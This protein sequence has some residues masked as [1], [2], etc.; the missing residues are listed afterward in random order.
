MT[1][2]SQQRSDVYAQPVWETIGGDVLRPGGLALTERALGL[3][4]IAPGARLLDAGCGPGASAA[5]AARLGYASVGLDQSAFLLRQARDRHGTLALLRAAAERLPLASATIDAVLAECSLSVVSERGE[6]LGEF[7][8][9][10]KPGGVLAV[11]DVYARNPDGL[12]A[13]RRLP[14]DACLSGALSEQQI[15]DMLRAHGFRLITWEDHS[16]T[17]KAMA[18]RMAATCGGVAGLCEQTAQVDPFDLQLAL[19]RARLGYF[20]LVAT[21]LA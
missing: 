9:V 21:K 7:Y 15:R 18:A 1:L 12:P 14:I 4:R 3:C 6:V 5:L 13:L 11:S 8:R 2:A 17:L 10:L 16:E 19:A 20:L